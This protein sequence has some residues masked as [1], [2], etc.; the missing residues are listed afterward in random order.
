VNAVVVVAVGKWAVQFCPLSHSLPGIFRVPS[1]I[2]QEIPKQVVI[3]AE[4]IRLAQ[5][6]N[7]RMLIP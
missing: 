2:P 1:A 3:N 7:M 4:V 6:F 5:Q